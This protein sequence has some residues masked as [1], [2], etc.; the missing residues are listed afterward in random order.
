[1]KMSESEWRAFLASDPP[2]TA[3]VATVRAD[4]RPHVIPVWYVVDGDRLFFS[5]G[6]SSVKANNLRRDSRIALCVDDE[7]PP[8]SFVMLEGSAQLTDDLDQ[9]R[10]WA[11][12]IGGR[13]MGADQAEAFGTRNA[14]P[15]ELLVR[16]DITRVVAEKDIASAPEAPG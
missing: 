7:A 4:G 13:Y 3:K 9:L 5:T 6:Q 1:M 12:E 2:H 16:V 8:F 11:T 14:V 15:R 10:R